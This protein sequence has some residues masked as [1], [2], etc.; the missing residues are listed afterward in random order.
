MLYYNLLSFMNDRIGYIDI[1]KA[2]AIVF[3]VMGHVLSWCYPNFVENLN[4]FSYN[5][6][7]LWK[8][9]YSFHM[10]LFMFISGMVVF[11]PLKQYGIKV[12]IKRII[13]YLIPFFVIG[14]LLTLYRGVYFDLWELL[15][16]LWYFR[17]LSIFIIAI[18]FPLFI[19]QKLN[20]VNQRV[21][22][23]GITIVYYSLMRFFIPYI[24]SKS[25]IIESALDLSLWNG[26][27]SLYPFFLVGFLYRR[28]ALMRKFV[29]NKY[30]YTMS[31]IVM[32]FFIIHPFYYTGVFSPTY[33]YISYIAICLFLN[34]SIQ[35]AKYIR[36]N[37]VLGKVGKQTLDIYILHSFFA[38]CV[39]AIGMLFTEIAKYGLRASISIQF[40]V[41]LPVTVIVIYLCLLLGQLIRDNNL[42]SFFCFGDLSIFKKV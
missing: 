6:I 23:L 11:N 26:H 38:T 3:V 7:A 20:Y 2:L 13:S 32:F 12:V 5:E 18:Y 24:G 42:L 35:L 17:T 10:P 21:H 30:T 14:T 25:I 8:I 29:E 22:L 4:N 37:E 19:F 1:L 9:I 16:R 36:A 40:F 31:I 34:V 15:N 39:P 27:I 28:I 41:A 33:T